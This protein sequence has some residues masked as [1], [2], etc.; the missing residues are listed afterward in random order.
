M[1]LTTFVL[2]RHDRPELGMPVRSPE[3]DVDVSG[4]VPKQRESEQPMH[5][6][7]GRDMLPLLNRNV[8]T[9][10]IDPAFLRKPTRRD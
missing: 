9:S 1:A 5:E 6:A 8:A 2:L 3:L 4:S 7:V 10:L